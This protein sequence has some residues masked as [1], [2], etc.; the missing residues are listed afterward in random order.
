MSNLAVD[1]HH[2][3]LLAAIRHRVY[4]IIYEPT[5]EQVEA[6]I[7][8]IAD[9]GIRGLSRENC[10]MAA[11]FLLEECK[12]REI[13]PSVRLLV[14]Q[15]LPDFCL[16]ESGR[17]GSHWRG[18]VVSEIEQQLI[19]IQHPQRDLRISEPMEAE[20]RIAHVI[21]S[22]FLSRNER[23]K[24]WQKITEERFG[25]A[26]SP[27]MFYRRLEELRKTTKLPTTNG[28]PRL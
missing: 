15:A 21:F 20:R 5:N 16:W 23:I 8:S 1:G 26:K 11:H 10:H 3:E 4:S 6:L 22:S 24:P 14:D 13:R 25:H 28:Y 2:P 18:L 7:H 17:T 9:Q 27:V 12:R 19:E